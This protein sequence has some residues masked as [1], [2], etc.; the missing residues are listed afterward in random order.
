[1]IK[2]KEKFVV[3]FKLDNKLALTDGAWFEACHAINS[4]GTS[5]G[6]L[7]I[8]D[9]MLE[10]FVDNF[11][12]GVVRRYLKDGAPRL[13]INYE[14][15]FDTKA[16]W[17]LDAEIRDKKLSNGDT[18]KSL[19]LKPSWLSDAAEAIKN[20][21]YEYFSIEFDRE[22]YD[23]QNNITAENVLTGGA[24]TNNP[25]VMEL[26]TIS[27]SV[28]TEK[29]E[30]DRE[31]KKMKELLTALKS[32]GIELSD[33]ATVIDVATA[34]KTILTEKKDA[35]TKLAETSEKLT[36]SET[37]LTETE[38]ALTDLT[39]AHTEVSEKLTASEKQIDEINAEKLTAEKTNLIENAIKD[40][41]FSKAECS[42]DGVFGKLIEKDIELA[43]EFVEKASVRFEVTGSNS[44]IET[45]T[46][47]EARAAEMKEL[48]ATGVSAMDAYNKTKPKV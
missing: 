35:E 46:S 9:E 34:F 8:T 47:D 6:N 41:K 30:N 10:M 36:A 44:Q 11:K 13:L 39:A 18:I 29:R 31:E 15:Y 1:M 38:T 7:S 19:W 27:L 3:K 37:K 32:D 45:L 22:F 5:K 17:I 42:P 33:D 2:E 24:L 4:K 20:D 40:L 26:E 16:G 28:L 21:K 14:H 12:A 25:F 43:R 23:D 48:M